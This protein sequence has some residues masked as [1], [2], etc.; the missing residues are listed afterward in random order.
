MA[1][2]GH[3]LAGCAFVRERTWTPAVPSDAVGRLSPDRHEVDQLLHG[4]D[5]GRFDI[6]VPT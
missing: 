5:E 3:D 4:V 1:R 2:C 6:A